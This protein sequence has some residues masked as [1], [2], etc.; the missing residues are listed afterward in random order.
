MNYNLPHNKFN[1]PLRFIFCKNLTCF[2]MFLVQVSCSKIKLFNKCS[3]YS[4]NRQKDWCFA[5]I[6]TLDNVIHWTKISE[7]GCGF[8]IDFPAIH[9][10]STECILHQPIT[11]FYISN[12][13][14]IN[15]AELNQTKT[16]LI[17]FFMIG[18]LSYE[19]KVTKE[20]NEL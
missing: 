14:N 12:D 15:L 11:N 17:S 19:T 9:K 1:I 18:C 6:S 10:K 3:K 5:Q 4:V 13:L 20:V 16:R 2:V 8:Y 7:P